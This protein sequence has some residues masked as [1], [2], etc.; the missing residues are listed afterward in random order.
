M[1][2]RRTPPLHR[3]I[4]VIGPTAGLQKVGLATDPK[5]RLAA[6]QTA[7]PFHLMLHA[8]VQVPS[9]EAHAVERRAHRLLKTAWVRNE[10]FQATP[11]EAV[12]AVQAAAG[13]IALPAKL[14]LFDF[15]ATDEGPVS[16]RLNL[17]ATHPLWSACR[18]MLRL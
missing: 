3:F 10:W 13:A 17:K 2:A 6:L 4:Y 14:P 1:P 7:C 11:D 5:T 18:A 16:R 9:G 8:S 15:D 12:A